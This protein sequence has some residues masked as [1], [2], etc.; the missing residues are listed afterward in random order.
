MDMDVDEYEASCV[1]FKGL[2]H[3]FTVG[4]FRFLWPRLLACSLHLVNDCYI[5]SENEIG[6][7]GPTN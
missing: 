2:S 6:N 1:P 4:A 3:T 5:A 7:S